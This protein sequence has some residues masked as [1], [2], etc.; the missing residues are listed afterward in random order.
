MGLGRKFE[1][2]GKEEEFSFLAWVTIDIRD[3]EVQNIEERVEW[4]ENLKV[5]FL[6]VNFLFD[7]DLYR[8]QI[9]MWIRN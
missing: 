4:R 5:A 7:F 6:S 3:T 1:E 8:K 9:K 2:M